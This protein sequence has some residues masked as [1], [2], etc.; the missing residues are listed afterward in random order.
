MSIEPSS[1][2]PVPARRAGA[3]RPL[4]EG[5]AAT[6]AT[7][8][9]GRV[10][11]GRSAPEGPAVKNVPTPGG[12]AGAQ[13][14][15]F[16]LPGEHFAA[17]LAFLVAGGVGLVW[18]SPELAAGLFP[19]PRVIA[20]VHLF[21]LGWITTSILGALYQFLPV[22]L[23]E[24][25]RSERVAHIGFVLY[26]PGLAV[27][28]V[29]LAA[30]VTVAY[31][32][33]AAAFCVGLLLFVWNLAA[34]L[35]RARRR[36]L[37]WWSLAGALAFLVAAISFGISLAGNLRWGYLGGDRFGAVAVHLHVAL[38]G[39]VFLVVVGVAQRLLPMFL[40]SHGASVRP[41]RWA[42]ALLA[43]GA[44]V[45]TLFHHWPGRVLPV[46]GALVWAGA[47]AFLVQSVLYFRHR[48]KSSLDAG[49]RL[50]GG[51]LGLLGL[52]LGI[53]PFAA[54]AGLGS[55]RLAS[56]Y[57]AALVGGFTL[58]VA[59]HDYKIVPFL[60]WYHRFGPLVGRRPV[61]VVAQLFSG[62]AANLAAS[63]LGAGAAGAVVAVLLATPW[64]VRAAAVAFA[65]GAVSMSLQMLVLSRRRPE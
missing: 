54:V 12:L 19:L 40:L 35:R 51:A 33:G 48:R 41:A 49:L 56:A 45:L 43:V 39:W 62:R 2:D 15:P 50:A 7:T 23:G 32:V 63:G 38:F 22:A 64:L 3:G 37:T 8:S 58:F 27:F 42:A 53:A 5:P 29:G 34:T 30:G 6:N 28:V 13:S 10:G 24:P 47:A 21:T 36:D 9:G 59:G 25:I 52:G 55:P 26:A 17:G 16:V 20:V 46:G 1:V 65:A 61:P 14:P 4:P 60:V 31:L 57:V 18:I 44:G 11:A